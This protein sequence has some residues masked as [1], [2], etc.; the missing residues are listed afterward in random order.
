MFKNKQQYEMTA[1]SVIA[2]L[3]H[4]LPATEHHGNALTVRVMDRDGSMMHGEKKKNRECEVRHNTARVCENYTS[5]KETRQMEIFANLKS[6]MVCYTES[7]GWEP[8]E[9]VWNKA[10]VHIKCILLDKWIFPISLA[11]E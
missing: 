1:L 7:S 2:E 9:T 3:L 5:R 6:Q 4:H 10:E 8:L 11:V